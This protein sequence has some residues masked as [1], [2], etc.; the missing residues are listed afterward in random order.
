MTMHFHE[1]NLKKYKRYTYWKEAKNTNY[2]QQFASTTLENQQIKS[3]NE[4]R[5]DGKIVIH[6]DDSSS[7]SPSCG[8]AYRMELSHF[9][10]REQWWQRSR[11]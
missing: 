10:A 3:N 5:R 2:L 7:R 1:C 11:P 4:K 9:S 6:H 8:I